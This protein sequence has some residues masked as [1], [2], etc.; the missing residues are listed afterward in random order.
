MAEA[1]DDW[2]LPSRDA[3]DDWRR[4]AE[5][6]ASPAPT[7][8]ESVGRAIAGDSRPDDFRGRLARALVGSSGLGRNPIPFGSSGFGVSLSDIA[9]PIEA[10][11]ATQEAPRNI[12]EGRYLET[13]LGLLNAIPAPGV[14]PT[15]RAVRAALPAAVPAG[16]ASP[17]VVDDAG[18][19]VVTRPIEGGGVE[20][21]VGGAAPEVAP[22]PEMVPARQALESRLS[23]AAPESPPAVAEA[24]P[25]PAAPELPAAVQAAPAPSAG[26]AVEIVTPDQSVRVMATPRLV[27]LDD[28]KLASGRFQPRDRSRLEYQQ[29]VRERATRLDPQQLQPGRVSDSGAPVIMPDGTVLSGNG[30]I[31]SIAEVYGDRYLV[32]QMAAYRQS[33]GPAARGMRQPVLVMEVEGLSADDA[34]RFADMSNRGRI[35]QMSITERAGRDA[36]AMGEEALALYRGGEFT[37]PQ[38]ADFLRAFTARAVTAAERPAFSSGADVTLEGIQRMRAAVLHGAYDDAALIARMLESADDN[39]KNIT[40]A[41]TDA[42]PG[43]ARLRADVR[44]GDVLPSLDITKQLTDAVKL[45]ADLRSRGISPASHFAQI[46]AFDRPDP[47]I[48]AIVRAFYNEDLTRAI[49]RQR[50]AE[51]LNFYAGEARHHVPG[52][53]F[54]DPTTARDVLGAAQRAAAQSGDRT[55]FIPRGAQSAGAGVPGGGG[56]P[57]GPSAFGVGA[58]TP[59]GGAAVWPGGQP[60]TD[61]STRDRLMEL[62]RRSDGQF[63]PVGLMA[64]MQRMRGG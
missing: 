9:F 43:F 58:L 56:A 10:I 62:L 8:R 57:Q 19:T 55:A 48:E 32:D 41:L 20:I 51:I 15:A 54:G 16:R 11:F 47:V 12:E 31:M 40:G 63:E 14:A 45:I 28:L 39:I 46:D 6:G 3:P 36:Q 23:G 42:A 53:L 27:E 35:A 61:L 22:T 37:S 4:P 2:V 49:S 59:A 50:M 33:L 38:N 7:W 64:A 29:E 30:R 25:A 17:G 1:R 26:R 24:V 60:E 18:R 44:A 21:R 34:A 52:G 5:M 13:A